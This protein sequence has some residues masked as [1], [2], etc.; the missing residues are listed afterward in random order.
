MISFT[1]PFIKWSLIS[2]KDLKV[3]DLASTH[4]K[5]I[6][7]INWV[8]SKESGMT[9]VLLMGKSTLTSGQICLMTSFTKSSHYFLTLLSGEI[10]RKWLKEI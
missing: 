1:D 10:Y 7:L 3:A 9:P 8:P 5:K 2:L 4:P 6:Y